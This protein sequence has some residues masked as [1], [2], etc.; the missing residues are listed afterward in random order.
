MHFQKQE[1]LLVTVILL[2]LL[3]VLLPL[4][5]VEEVNLGQEFILPRY[6]TVVVGSCCGKKNLLVSYER[7]VKTKRTR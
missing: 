1:T 2:E 6:V 4:D 5:G 3:G 7:R